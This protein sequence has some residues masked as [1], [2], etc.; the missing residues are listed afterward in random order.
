MTESTSVSTEDTAPPTDR[1][2]FGFDQSKLIETQ[3]RQIEAIGRASAIISSTVSAVISKQFDLLQ[4]E[5]AQFATEMEMFFEVRNPADVVPKQ[6]TTVRSAFDETL[7]D[8]REINDITRKGTIELFDVLRIGLPPDLP[9]PPPE[10]HKVQP[11]P[12]RAA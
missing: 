7:A 10:V 3:Q 12:S 9:A 11:R 6:L 1:P 4:K 2:P 5:V 8:L